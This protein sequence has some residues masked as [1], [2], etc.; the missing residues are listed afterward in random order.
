MCPVEGPWSEPP[1]QRPAVSARP[2]E[3]GFVGRLALEKGLPLLVD[4]CA[5]LTS[6]GRDLRLTVVGDGPQRSII[7]AHARERGISDRI[8]FLGWVRKA[9]L[10]AVFDQIDLLVMP[11]ISENQGVAAQEAMLHGV[12]VVA[13]SAGGLRECIRPGVD[14]ELAEPGNVDSLVLALERALQRLEENPYQVPDYG[15]AR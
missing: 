4:A 11:S 5:E 15:L 10:L 1:R 8:R 7:E 3:L 13:S 6:R 2:V 12:P 9:K 14:G